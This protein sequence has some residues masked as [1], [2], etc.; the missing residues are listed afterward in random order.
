MPL[1]LKD[2][3]ISAISSPVGSSTELFSPAYF[4]LASGI[5]QSALTEL[6]DDD[7]NDV[8]LDDDGTTFL[9]DD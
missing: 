3:V 4:G 6:L 7:G 5:V 2:T 8:L 9:V 1:E